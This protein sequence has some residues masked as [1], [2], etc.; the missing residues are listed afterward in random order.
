QIARPA[1]TRNG[2]ARNAEHRPDPIEGG[3]AREGEPLGRL[4]RCGGG[5][6]SVDAEEDL[7][8]FRPTGCLHPARPIVTLARYV[9]ARPRIGLDLVTEQLAL[10]QEL[11]CQRAV[12]LIGHDDGM[13][14]AGVFEG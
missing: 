3:G 12:T 8:E 7:I 9:G 6:Q 2:D 11:P 1:Q 14:L 5:Y 4:T 10:R 13:R